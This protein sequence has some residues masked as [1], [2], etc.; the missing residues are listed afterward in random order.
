MGVRVCRDAPVISHLLFADDSLILMHAD[1]K[2]ADCLMDIL[3]R[4]CA[5][6]G[7][8]ISEAKSSIYFSRNT[9]VDTRAEVCEAL[10][11]MIES[12]SD[13]YLGLPA[14]VGADRSDCF[15]HQIDRVNSRINGWKEKLLSM[16]GKEILIKS[17]A[18]AVPVYAM[19]VFKVPKKICKGITDA[20]SRFWWGDDND[21]KRMHRL[22]WWKLCVPKAKGSMEFRDLQSFNL[23]MLAKQVW[24]LLCE[25]ESLCARVLRARYYPDGNLLNAKMKS[26]SSYTWQSVLVGLECFKLGYIWRV[27]DGTQINIWDDNWIPGSHNMKIQMPRGN[28]IVKTVD[29][30]INPVDFT[31][32]ADL[33]RS[34]FW[35]VDAS[36]ILQI[37]ITP[38]REDLVAWHFNRSGMFSVKSAY[39]GQ[40]KKNFGNRLNTPTTESSTRQVWKKLWKLHVP[41]KIKIFGWR[42]LCGLLPC[43]A[44]LANRHIVPN[45]GCPIC[46]NGAEDVKHVIFTCDRAKAV[47][48][49]MGLGLKISDL[50]ATDQ[51]GSIVLEEVIRGGEQVQGLEVGLAEL[52]LTG[53]WF[54][55]WERRQI[56]HGEPVQHAA[57]SGLSIASLT[58]NYKMATGDDNEGPSWME[59]TPRGLPNGEY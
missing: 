18:Q 57:R 6:S 56:V 14:M 31:W 43:R 50:L 17:V 13:K 52:V 12:L 40:W 4:Y 36:R 2:N 30:L 15:H 9:Q 58:K 44:I 23:A 20:I 28:N 59:E 45:G 53:G 16:G 41:G 24:R 37:P 46:P 5:I 55:W 42:A 33:I 51:S 38:G 34:I 3:N 21:Q 49:S 29:E 8:K 39:H 25:P 32:D 22:E 19:M 48:S 10:N 7:Q 54:L 27:G 26:G 35:G 11:I 1:R 47:W